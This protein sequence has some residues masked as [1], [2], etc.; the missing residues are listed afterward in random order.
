MLLLLELFAAGVVGGG[1]EAAFV[2]KGDCLLALAK[3]VRELLLLTAADGDCFVAAIGLPFKVEVLS[4]LL[5]LLLLFAV[6]LVL[7]G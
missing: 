6:L 3:E 4:A 5:L 1:A 2:D 7:P